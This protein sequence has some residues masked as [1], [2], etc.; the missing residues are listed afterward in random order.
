LI[1]TLLKNGGLGACP[2]KVFEA[3]PSRTSENALFAK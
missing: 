2:Q 1:V 3:T